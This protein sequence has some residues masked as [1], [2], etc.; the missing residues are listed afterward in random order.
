MM[1]NTSL[2]WGAIGQQPIDINAERSDAILQILDEG[3]EKAS[4]SPLVHSGAGEVEITEQ[5]RAGMR[6]ALTT[7]RAAWRRKMTILP[8]TESRSS[9]SRPR[10]DGRTDIPIFFSDIREE[11]D[12][13]DPH[14]IVECKRI[15]G[16]RADLC[17]EYVVEGIDRF[18]TGKYAGNHAVGFMAGYVLSDDAKAATAGINRHLTRKGRQSEH[19][20]P[21]SA[22]G[23]PWAKT[24]RHT[25]QDPRTPI[26]L[27][28]AF[29]GFR[30]PPRRCRDGSRRPDASRP[31]AEADP[32]Q[33]TVGTAN[34]L[35][36]ENRICAGV[37]REK[38]RKWTIFQ[39]LTSSSGRSGDCPASRPRNGP[40][41]STR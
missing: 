37:E 16:N 12:E 24:S 40:S 30:P 2:G 13:H 9:P 19:L 39:L 3:W 27:H 36:N 26:T 41:E 17:R 22:P 32:D 1:S 7:K 5:L 21:C 33:P 38:P 15:A 20:G 6:T 8:G 14:A 31:H 10:P 4:T 29:F 35:L 11:Y 28:H 23:A 25:R 18:V 34:R